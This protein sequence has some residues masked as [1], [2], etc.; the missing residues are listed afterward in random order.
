MPNGVNAKA[1]NTCW[2]G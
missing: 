1:I 2:N